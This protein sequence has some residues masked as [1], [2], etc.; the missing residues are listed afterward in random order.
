[1]LPG[2]PQ[3][4]PGDGPASEKTRRMHSREKKN[5]AHETAMKITPQTSLNLSV[6]LGFALIVLLMVALTL[7]GLLRIA[8][9]NRHMERLVTNNK[10]KTDLV[11]T[12]KDAF[13][14]RAHTHA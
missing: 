13:G 1:M 11:H 3:S 5:T 12:M 7:V 14:E 2:W 9:L 8:E 6:I 10:V 4:G